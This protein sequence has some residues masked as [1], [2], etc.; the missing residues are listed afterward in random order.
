[1][2]YYDIQIFTRP[3]VKKGLPA[4]LF[5]QYSSLRNGVF[6]PGNLM[7]EFD[8]HRFE[9][10]TPQNETLITIWGISPE[11][12]QQ[13]R[14]NMFGMTLKM[15]VGMSKGLP[16]ANAGHQGLVLEGTIWQVIGNWQGTELR[17]DLIVTASPVSTTDMRPLAP[18]NLTLPWEKGRKLSN[19]LF[20]CLRILGDYHFSISISDRLVNNFDNPMFCGSMTELARQLK[21]TS[22][23]IIREPWYSGVVITM[24]NAKTIRVFDNDV[25]YHPDKGNKSAFYRSQN[26]KQILFTDLIGQ[27]AWVTFGKVSIPCVMRNDIQVGDY[28]RMP[29]KMMPMVRASSYSQFREDAA[30]T[31]EFCVSSVRLIG[32]SRQPDANSWI[33]LIEAYPVGENI[34]T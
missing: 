15:S 13:A 12:M 23:N 1:M 32:N 22:K 24:V 30:F 6:N 18:L 19:A 7:V 29:E 2:R 17:L 3:D 8:I 20:D 27:P 26:P 33:T 9:E 25:E 14:Q 21:K 11:E 10:S 28:I 16:L 34:E 4:K 31:G 5:R